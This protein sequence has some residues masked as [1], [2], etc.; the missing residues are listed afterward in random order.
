VKLNDLSHIGRP[1]AN[2]ER[3]IASARRRNMSLQIGAS[4]GE[5]GAENIL[6]PGGLR[7]SLKRLSSDKE[8]QGKPS[9][10]LGLS[11]R[12]L[13]PIWLNLVI[14]GSDLAQF[15]RAQYGKRHMPIA[16]ANPTA[17]ATSVPCNGRKT[18]KVTGL[19]FAAKAS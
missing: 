6:G 19:P 14:F 17:K 16:A 2:E 13:G 1:G 5:R 7:K 12:G 10:F 3:R 4:E 15:Q 18:E 11:L 9:R 8:I